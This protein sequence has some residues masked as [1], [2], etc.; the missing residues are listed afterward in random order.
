MSFLKKIGEQVNVLGKKSGEMLEVTKLKLA[1]AKLE[2]EVEE[3]KLALG[4]LCYEAYLEGKREEE[5]MLSLCKSIDELRAE[6]E[7][8]NEEIEAVQK[9]GQGSEAPKAKFCSQCGE[10]QDAEAKFCRNC[11]NKL[12]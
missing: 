3:K 5:E 11:G 2:K 8:I 4:H 10:K 6:I 12:E 7:K 1:C 9:E